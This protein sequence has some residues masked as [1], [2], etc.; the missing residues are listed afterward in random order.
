MY[1]LDTWEHVPDHNT[2][3]QC[4]LL[5]SS[6]NISDSSISQSIYLFSF[7]FSKNFKA[8]RLSF[9]LISLK[10][11]STENL[12][13]KEWEWIYHDALL[14]SITQS[15]QCGFYHHSSV[16]LHYSFHSNP[17]SHTMVYCDIIAL[18]CI[19][20]N[21]ECRLF[22]THTPIQMLRL[23]CSWTHTSYNPLTHWATHRIQM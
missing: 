19:E 6:K 12:W 13:D 8:L 4:S 7:Y 16:S 10:W 1:H 9:L 5:P 18:R 23:L 22:R 21:C 3:V 2:N 20:E 11:L 17:L 14:A 15:Y